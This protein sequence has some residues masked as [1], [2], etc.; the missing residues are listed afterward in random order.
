MIACCGKYPSWIRRPVSGGVL[1]S[2]VSA[3]LGSGAGGAGSGAQFRPERGGPRSSVVWRDVI[4]LEDR[5]RGPCGEMS[6]N[7]VWG[8]AG[9]CDPTHETGVRCSWRRRRATSRRFDRLPGRCRPRPAEAAGARGAPKRYP[10]APTPSGPAGMC[11][12]VGPVVRPCRMQL[13]AGNQS[14][15]DPASGAALES[16]R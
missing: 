1:A 16:G 7:A 10:G 6:P 9:P 3:M 12:H 11:A 15:G 2:C 4:S 8:P 13:T 5:R 14:G